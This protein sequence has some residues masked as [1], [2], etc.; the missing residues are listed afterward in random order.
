MSYQEEPM[1]RERNLES[2][3]HSVFID[4]HRFF[5]LLV[6]DLDSLDAEERLYIKQIYNSYSRESIEKLVSKNQIIPFAAHIFTNLD[7]DSNFWRSKYDYYVLRNNEIRSM[8]EDVF[9]AL[10][11]YNCSSITLTENFAALLA[12]ESNIGCFCSGD[13]DL[14]ADILEQEKITECMNSIGFYSKEQPRSIG[15][16][17]G[18]SMQFFNTNV[19]SDGFWINVIWKPVTRAFLVQDKYEKRLSRDRL[20]ATTLEGS[21]I[22]ILESTSLLYFCALH[23]A[24]G[25]YFTLTPG[26]R[27]YVDIDR[28]V[29]N[30]NIDWDDIIAWEQEDDAGIRISMSLYLSKKLLKTPIPEKAYKNL[31]LK[32]RNR[33][34]ANYLLDS[35]SNAIQSKSSKI[36]R[37]Y[38]ELL[39]D[40]KFMF[41]N[42]IRRFYITISSK[43]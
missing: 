1:K 6:R 25:H 32:K 13:V 27:L 2:H 33:R 38:V 42:L 30:V 10:K 21:S 35:K 8:L 20:N 37:L 11:N 36:R 15:E 17:S 24:A 34:L 4:Q 18:Q 12:S 40:N 28:I 5:P 29:R 16:Y 23:S 41:F 19:L 9:I 7:C 39:S 3:D 22:R 31:F 43:L 14:S 26:L